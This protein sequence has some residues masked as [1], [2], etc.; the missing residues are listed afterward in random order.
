MRLALRKFFTRRISLV[1][2]IYVIKKPT[3]GKIRNLDLWK[4]ARENDYKVLTTH[5]FF[6]SH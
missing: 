6:F 2:K 1:V 5:L 3:T 4:N